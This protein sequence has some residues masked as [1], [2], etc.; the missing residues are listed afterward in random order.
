MSKEF[1]INKFLERFS[2][3]QEHSCDSDS[4]L[5]GA[6]EELDNAYDE[7]PEES[8]DVTEAILEKLLQ[9]FCTAL[10][11]IPISCSS[12]LTSDEINRILDK[13]KAIL[14]N[15]LYIE[16]VYVRKRI[17]Y[18]SFIVCYC[19]FKCLFLDDPFKSMGI[20]ENQIFNIDTNTVN[21]HSAEKPNEKDNKLKNLGKVE[22]NSFDQIVSDL[23]K[24]F[25]LLKLV[26]K[27]CEGDNSELIS[28]FFELMSICYITYPKVTALERYI[29]TSEYAITFSSMLYRFTNI[30]LTDKQI[31]E[32]NDIQKM[33]LA[34]SF[35]IAVYMDDRSIL[36]D[37]DL[38]ESVQFIAETIS[39]IPFELPQKIYDQLVDIAYFVN[40][41]QTALMLFSPPDQ[42]V[43]YTSLSTF[44]FLLPQ[45][46]QIENAR[47]NK[48]TQSDI[49]NLL[50]PTIMSVVTMNDPEEGY[51]VQD[52]LAGNLDV[53]RHQKRHTFW[54]RE[55]DDAEYT[56]NSDVHVFCR[57]FSPYERRDDL[58]MWEIYGDRAKGCCAVVHCKDSKF[59]EIEL[60]QI[61][62]FKVNKETGNIELVEVSEDVKGRNSIIETNIKELKNQVNEIEKEKKLYKLDDSS[63]K[64][65]IRYLLL[66][67]AY[68][69]KDASY[70]HEREVRYLKYY[71]DEGI[72]DTHDDIQLIERNYAD[73]KMPLLG[74]KAPFHL[75]FDEV[76]LAPKVEE[77]NV[78][79]AY[80]EYAFSLRC[81]CVSKYNE[82]NI[83]KLFAPECTTKITR[84][85]INYR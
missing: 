24:H 23:K 26:W 35:Q 72:N 64:K 19:R 43:Y 9:K 74:I 53:Q 59:N 77:P 29:E 80:L 76:I 71:I 45:N 85:M 37:G 10:Y 61:C 30:F 27:L 57:C 18:I 68:L 32:S 15:R 73:G 39:N 14:T 17:P 67:I 60:F 81:Q 44:R 82:A 84:S 21:T 4:E 47:T 42:L 6:K 25:D 66:G 50:K 51:Y 12:I 49:D 36:E 5:A 3:H 55:N 65:A 48:I 78:V 46:K 41:I 28:L 2:F 8:E 13:M 63:I 20:R 69:F 38:S 79:A 7:L 33:I 52:Y 11:A 34:R 83:D 1:T 70:A 56:Y 75:F 31:K 62:Y 54:W 58:S 16:L 40:C 22:F